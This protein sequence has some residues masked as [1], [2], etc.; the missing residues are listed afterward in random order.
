MQ[1]IDSGLGQN[2]DHSWHKGGADGTHFLSFQDRETTFG[3]HRTSMDLRRV[4]LTSGRVEFDLAIK[5]AC[6]MKG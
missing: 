5:S 1:P 4:A 3:L 6:N 2:L